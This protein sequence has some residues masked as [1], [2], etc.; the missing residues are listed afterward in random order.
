MPVLPTS[1]WL[2]SR[3]FM[4][5][6]NF[7]LGEFACQGSVFVFDRFQKQENIKLEALTR[8]QPGKEE[9]NSTKFS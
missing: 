1:Q 3:G 8:V 6:G 2:H 5:N 4:C 9:G 7:S